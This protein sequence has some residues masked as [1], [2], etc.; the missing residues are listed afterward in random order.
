MGAHGADLRFLLLPVHQQV[1]HT[2]QT[3]AACSRRR[4]GRPFSSARWACARVIM[5]SLLLDLVRGALPRVL[6]HVPLNAGVLQANTY[7][8]LDALP[9]ITM[10]PTLPVRS[11]GR[12]GKEQP[13]RPPPP[14]WRTTAAYL[15][16]PCIPPPGP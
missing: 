10:L 9:L 12:A 3:N 2:L 11:R 7:T 15:P 16:G 14:R 13:C 4:G 5:G 8:F 1:I 6:P